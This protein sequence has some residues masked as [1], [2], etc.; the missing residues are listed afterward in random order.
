MAHP[1]RFR[2]GVQASTAA[3]G[4]DW[5]A[6]ARRVE[7]LGY[8]TLFMPDHFGDQLAPVPALM[9]AADATS[10]LRI[11][12]LVFDNDYKHPVVLAKEAATLDLLSG[13]RLELGVGAGWMVSDYEQA[14]MAYDP[15]KVRVD[16]FAEGLAVIKGLFAEGELHFE[17]EHYR[18]EGLDGRPKPVARP[19]PPILIGGGAKR[20]LSIAAR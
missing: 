12:A 10:E 2:F 6:L 4:D 15:P 20:M 5:R 14:G 9:A 7:D 18:I 1:R 17:G 8:S 19:H 16:R 13:G 3:S 11:G